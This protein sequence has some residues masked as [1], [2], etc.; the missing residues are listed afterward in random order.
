[1]KYATS[2]HQREYQRLYRRR[3]RAALHAQIQLPV[4][5]RD[6]WE[7]RDIRKAY[8]RPAPPVGVHQFIR[9]IPPPFPGTVAFS[10]LYGSR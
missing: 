1:M 10:L 6:Q 2:L 5:E 9:S 8:V 3:A 7:L 4:Q